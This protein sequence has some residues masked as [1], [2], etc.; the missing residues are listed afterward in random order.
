HY[1]N[2]ERKGDGALAIGRALLEQPSAHQPPPAPA[3]AG[4][5]APISS[6]IAASTRPARR[7][8]SEMRSGDVMNE[9]R[10]NPSPPAPKPEPGITITPSSCISLSAN[11]A[12]GT[13]EGKGIQR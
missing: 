7:A 4:A 3:P 9:M 2:R 5:P 11:A 10:K 1:V 12:L 6:V 8:A 13:C